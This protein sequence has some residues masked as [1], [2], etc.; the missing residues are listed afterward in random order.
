M[1]NDILFIVPSGAKKRRDAIFKE[2]VSRHTGNDYSSVR[3]LTP[4]NFVITEAK[5][6]FYSFIQA[7][8]KRSAF[9]PFQFQ[10]IRQYAEDLYESCGESGIVS[11]RLRVLILTEITGEKSVGYPTILADLL[12][13]I[14]HYLPDRDLASL[15]KEIKHLI[16]EEKA[17]D[18]ALGAI[19]ILQEYEGL[20]RR[21][22]LIDREGVLRKAVVRRALNVERSNTND[23]STL[24]IDGFFDPTPLELQ[25][26][27]TLMS[28]AE[29]VFILAE[30]RTGMFNY[31]KSRQREMTVKKMNAPVPRETAFFYSYPSIEDEVEGI[32][33]SIKKLI[34]EGTKP[35]DITVCFPVL[36]RYL[37]MVRRTLYKHG[38][39][40]GIGEYSMSSSRP[41]IALG[42]MITCIEEDYSRNDFLSFLTSPHFP[43][44]PEVIKERAVSYSY[45]AGVIKGK[46]AWLS[47]KDTLLN[48]P[49]TRFSD[50]DMKLIEK[51][52]T[53]IDQLVD[54]FERLKQ[55]KESMPFIDAFESALSQLGFFESMVRPGFGADGEKSLDKIKRQFSEFRYFAGLHKDTIP[56]VNSPVFYLKYFLSSISGSE[57][58]RDGIRVISFELAAGCETKVL[59]FAGVREGDFPSRPGIDPILP[60]NVKKELGIPHLEFYLRRQ[61]RYFERLLNVSSRDPYFSCPA[62][63]GD[64]VFLPSPFLDW[65]KSVSPPELAIFTDEEALIREGA[66]KLSSQGLKIFHDRDMFRTRE[67]FSL[68]T[69]RVTAITKGFFSVTDIDFYRKCPLRYYIERILGLEIIIPPQ[70]EIEARLWG[71]LAHK[72]MEYVFMDGGIE[73]EDLDREIPEGLAKS[74][75]QFPIGDFWARVAK[76]IFLKLLP[77]IKEQEADIQMQGFSPFRTEEKLKG[78]IGSLRLRGKV[79]R[80]DIKG[81]DATK[82]RGKGSRSDQAPAQSLEDAQSDSVILIDYKT[83]NIDR[84][85]LQLPLYAAMWQESFSEPVEKLGYYSLKEGKVT[86]YPGKKVTL[87]EYVESA[88][89]DAEE[90]SKQIRKGVFTPEPF[91]ADEC[92]YCYHESLCNK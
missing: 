26:I 73:P 53:G 36:S 14:I 64:K 5:S 13:K 86:W 69:G 59:F 51:F 48:A 88:V 52:Q 9:V 41:F 91:K 92:R 28:N 50:D 33:K 12:K 79:D 80:V 23:D 58:N 55:V 82:L 30:E 81:V 60:E 43:A 74:L 57:E 17:A 89:Q 32:A 62:A 85:S 21:K 22:N 11:D 54:T 65:E 67:A 6:A 31:I 4:N 18:R 84:D 42:E 90:L 27:D 10:T 87:Q 45:S 37:P 29:T 35:W 44:I 20:L 1:G 63:D 39:P 49:R 16:F 76:E 19:K 46:D 40:A 70:F 72:T 66:I 47:I 25:I 75:K 34:M 56:Y 78:E 71:N 3:Y 8:D 68:L 61:K 2:I 7:R 24:I 77:A 15:R 83:G 38:I